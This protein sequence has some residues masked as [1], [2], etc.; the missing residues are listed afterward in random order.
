[1]QTLQFIIFIPAQEPTYLFVVVQ[2]NRR[3]QQLG[4]EQLPQVQ[5]IGAE[6]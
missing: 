3:F 1:M 5:E 4:L 2:S 6:L